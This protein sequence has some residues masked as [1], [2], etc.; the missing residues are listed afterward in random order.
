MTELDAADVAHQLRNPLQ[1]L[2]LRLDALALH[3]PPECAQEVEAALREARHLATVLDRLLRPAQPR[4]VDAAAI[5]GERIAAWAPAARAKRMTVGR[6]GA[7][8]LPALADPVA[9]ASALDVVL[10]NAI[11]FAP[12]GSAVHVWLG[13]EPGHAVIAVR[14]EGP[15]LRG[16]TGGGRGLRIARTLLEPTGRL[17]LHGAH[18]S[19]LEARIRLPATSN[20]PQ[21]PPAN[22]TRGRIVGTG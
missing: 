3:A 22:G 20:L 17:E 7:D 12:P 5:A 13:S 2:L 15:G 6:T 19:G 9:L 14:D 18:P 11:K 10:D 1:A 21:I 8:T 16:E 4:R